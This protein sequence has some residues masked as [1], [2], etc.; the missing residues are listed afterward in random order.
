MKKI[1]VVSSNEKIINTVREGCTAFSDDFG[2][3][4]KTDID[5]IISYINYELPEIKVLDYTSANIDYDTILSE[6]NADP[7]LHYGGIIAVCKDRKQMR[8]LE[9][10]K[11]SNILSIQTI[12]DFSF[13]FIHLLRI[14]WQNQK[15][16]LSRGMQEDFGGEENGTFVCGNDPLD[17]RFYTS[18]LINY[19]YSTNRINSDDRSDL[20]MTLTELLTNALE[21]GNLHIS[22]DE[23]TRWM[24]EHGDI[25]SLIAERAADPRYANKQITIKYAIGKRKSVVS[26][27]DE[28]DG[29]DWRKYVGKKNAH[30][31]ELHGRGIGLASELV[32]KIT[33][34]EKGNQVVFEIDNR[35]DESNTVP[36]VMSNFET[37]SYTD[38]QI[39]CRQNEAT[40]DLFFI[41]SGRY[42]VYSGRKLV[43]VMSPNDV[44]IGDMSFL[45]N[46]KRSATILAVGNCKLIKIPKGD[47]LQMIRKNPHYGLFLSRMLAQRLEKQTHRTIE[48][49]E[50][51]AK[52]RESE[53]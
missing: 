51:I 19:L 40:T 5:D 30:E 22:Y 10:L 1:L 36:L 2:I 50:K 6:V 27:Q 3:D 35:I 41:V 4:I 21:H 13:H 49:N 34:N 44:F 12:N 16:L 24:E 29:F 9:D 15:F 23:K 25:F 48:L 20:Q 18:F 42:A 14:L 37:I 53:K 11:D 8:E 28:G 26:I 46:D 43:T 47:F 38:K 45:L 39:V 31:G 52:L 7:W 32:S 33:Y 17:I